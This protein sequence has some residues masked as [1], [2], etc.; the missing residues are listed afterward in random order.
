MLDTKLSFLLSFRYKLI[1]IIIG[2]LL[3]TMVAVGIE[4]FT[5]DL[6]TR[7]IILCIGVFIFGFVGGYKPQSSDP[8]TKQAWDKSM[9]CSN[10]AFAIT[11]SVATVNTYYAVHHEITLPGLYL[12]ALLSFIPLY[13][14]IYAGKYIGTQL[15]SKH[16]PELAFRAD[17][18]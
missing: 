6:T 15:F 3:I 16:Y 7:L 5:Y 4:P 13:V 11:I 10:F 17:L 1:I 18:D 8:C 12:L 9:K 2:S 14:L